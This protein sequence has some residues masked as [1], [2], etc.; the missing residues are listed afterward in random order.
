[1]NDQPTSVTVSADELKRQQ[2]QLEKVRNQRH[3]DYPNCTCNVLAVNPGTRN[4]DIMVYHNP[5]CKLHGDK[6]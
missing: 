6:R 4:F 3:R 1:M 2:A 5:G